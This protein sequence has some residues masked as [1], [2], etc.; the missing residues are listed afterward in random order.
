[1]YNQCILNV[2]SKNGFNGYEERLLSKYSKQNRN[3]SHYAI[4]LYCD[5]Q[6][7]ILH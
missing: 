3:G 5:N 1:M 4:L 7:L 2:Q 6:M